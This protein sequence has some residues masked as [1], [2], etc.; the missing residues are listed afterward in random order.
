[1][2]CNRE[3]VS[4]SLNLLTSILIDAKIE[5]ESFSSTL[6][7]N[8]AEWCT[9]NF[10]GVKY[11]LWGDIYSIPLKDFPIRA[12]KH[13]QIN[14]TSVL[15]L[16]TMFGNLISAPPNLEFLDLTASR[17]PFRIAIGPGEQ[18]SCT[19]IQLGFFHFSH[20]RELCVMADTSHFFSEEEIIISMACLLFANS[21][22]DISN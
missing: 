14:I 6:C 10:W 1:M 4:H 12:L 2:C 16:T 15:L 17:T 9:T 7:G 13:F 3:S 5:P 19:V 11:D 8:H 22:W 20:L 18:R 21:H